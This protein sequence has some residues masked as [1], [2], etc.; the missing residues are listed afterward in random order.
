[1]NRGLIAQVR[2]GTSLWRAPYATTIG[3][4]WAKE[5]I[6]FLVC[7]I[8]H[9]KSHSWCRALDSRRVCWPLHIWIRLLRAICHYRRKC[10]GPVFEHTPHMD[11]AGLEWFD[12]TGPH[13]W[14]NLRGVHCA[15]NRLVSVRQIPGLKA[16]C[17][18]C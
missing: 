5:A 17:C 3:G 9:R 1:M 6:Q 16:R 10:P 13:C 7:G 11:G 2:I 8:Q 18:Q 15:R 12:Y 14:P 4:F